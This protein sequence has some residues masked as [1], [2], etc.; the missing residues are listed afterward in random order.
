MS[1][2]DQFPHYVCTTEDG[3]PWAI[4]AY[5]RID[6]AVF[7]GGEGKYKAIASELADQ[8]G[9]DVSDARELLVSTPPSRFHIHDSRD[10][11]EDC[12]DDE[13]VW[14]FCDEDAPGA[15]IVTGFKFC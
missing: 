14:Y 15:R 11:G 5:G 12:Q 13:V 9:M 6:F 3:E 10:R 4:F 7:P 2:A 1:K 8:S